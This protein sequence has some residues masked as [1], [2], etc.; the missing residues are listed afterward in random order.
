MK[1]SSSDRVVVITDPLWLGSNSKGVHQADRL[2]AL[3]MG[4]LSPVYGCSRSRP[5][6][7]QTDGM[8]IAIIGMGFR[9]KIF[10]PQRGHGTLL[11]RDAF[12]IMNANHEQA[13]IAARANRTPRWVS[14]LNT[15]TAI[16]RVK[17][18][19]ITNEP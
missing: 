8:V 12:Q 3:I 14:S 9:K 16:A 15:P 4:V 5:Q 6:F 1:I 19:S 7:G 17:R 2:K 11:F 10:Q 13:Q 18:N